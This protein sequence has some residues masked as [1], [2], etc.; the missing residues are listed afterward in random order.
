M[1]NQTMTGRRHTQRGRWLYV[2]VGVLLWAAPAPGQGFMVKPMKMEFSPRAGT[3]VTQVLELR[4]TGKDK[5]HILDLRLVQLSQDRKGGWKIIEPESKV[6]TSKLASCL[7]WVKLS[8]DNVT[9]KPLEMNP[10]TVTLKV[11]RGAR[12]Y[13]TAGIIAQ[14]RA[15]RADRGISV[16]IRFLIPIL[17]DIQ[18]RPVRQRIEL[19]DVTMA[20]RKA[21]EKVLATTLVTLG[22]TNKGRT[23]SRI[24]GVVKLEYQLKNRWR[25]V[26]RAQYKEM[27]ILPDVVFALDSDIKKRLPT[28]KYR[29]S[30][31]LYVNG[32]RVKPLVKEID[33][34]GDPNV[35]KLTIDTALVLEP[36][37]VDLKCVPGSTRTAVIKVE[38][39]SEDA[40][41]I[42]AVAVIPPSLA[43][44]ALGKLK[45]VDLSAAKWLR[46]SPAKFKLRGGRKQNVRLIAKMPRDK[47]IHS[48][49]YGLVTLNASYPDGQS[50]GAT[51]A[52]VTIINSKVEAKPAAQID[53]LTMAVGEG[54]V[55]IIQTK[56][57][58]IGGVHFTPKCRATLLGGMGQAVRE[59]ILSGEPGAMLPLQLRNFSGEMDFKGVKVG[60][61]QLRASLDYAPGKA[62]TRQIMVRVAVEDGQKVVTVVT[63]DKKQPTTAPAATGGTGADK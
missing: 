38:N 43:G 5:S 9:V 10:V 3:T 8:A 21:T 24:K 25:P 47:A 54:A 49:Y 39:A 17:V 32:R 50:A 60:V 19:S 40:V 61:Y 42:Q 26:S 1:T 46:I 16:V 58:N 28:G 6:D 35:T 63:L 44:V 51:T 14:I 2:V 4:N 12:G 45:G 62:A 23:Y 22:V 30:A 18:G 15:K 11:P 57:A 33:F 55:Y 20:H 41:T 37:Q 27:G 48:N 56:G 31:F 59:T 7:K 13:Y 53:K 36:L 52:L 29:L 34:K